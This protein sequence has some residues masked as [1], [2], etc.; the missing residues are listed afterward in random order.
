MF[1]TRAPNGCKEHSPLFS[2]MRWRALSISSPLHPGVKGV[3]LE[4]PLRPASCEDSRAIGFF[5]TAPA[6][7]RSGMPAPNVA[8]FHRSDHSSR[9]SNSDPGGSPLPL[10]TDD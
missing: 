6:S 5:S 9:L 3:L 2:F 7:P 10:F 8:Q 1:S 4:N